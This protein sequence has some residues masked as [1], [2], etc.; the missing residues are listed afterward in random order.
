MQTMPDKEFDELFRKKFESY[1]AEPSAAVWT[2]I[3]S[4]LN[5]SGRR[6]RPFSITWSVAASIVFMVGAGLW[7]A[8]PSETIKLRGRGPEQIAEIRESVPEQHVVTEEPVKKESFIEKLAS[9]KIK[10]KQHVASY[11]AARKDRSDD[12]EL[13]DTAEETATVHK[14]SPVHEDQ[15]Q[16]EKSLAL[17]P[18]PAPAMTN[19]PDPGKPVIASAVAAVRAGGIEDPE[20]SRSGIRTVGDLVNF[21][22]SKVD[23]RKDKLIEFSDSEEGTLI[24]G[25]N[26]GVLRLKTKANRDKQN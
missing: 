3:S 15:I 9:L 1:E 5:S 6:K 17:V 10:G 8:R 4:G 13:Y 12:N 2:A 23:H 18:S 7:I 11:K 19:V 20:S 24:S 25:I 26:L 14:I 16:P 22:V 21:V